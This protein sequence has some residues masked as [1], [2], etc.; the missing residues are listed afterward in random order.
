MVSCGRCVV[1]DCVTVRVCVCAMFC[2]DMTSQLNRT[3]RTQSQRTQ[4]RT[5]LAS[6]RRWKRKTI[7]KVSEG[8]H[9]RYHIYVIIYIINPYL[10]LLGLFESSS[11]ICLPTSRELS[12]SLLFSLSLSLSWPL[13][14]ICNYDYIFR[15]FKN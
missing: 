12:L 2:E 15:N 6:R 3:T 10:F 4:S 13:I 9:F 8:K 14:F 11:L 5:H 1:C 7:L